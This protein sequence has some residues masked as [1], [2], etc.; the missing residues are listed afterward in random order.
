MGCK[1]SKLVIFL[2]CM[3]Q[4]GTFVECVD[5]SGAK[6]GKCLRNISYPHKRNMCVGNNIL[7]S[8]KKRT[9][10]GQSRVPNKMYPSVLVLPSKRNYRID[11]SYVVNFK[12]SC[13]VVYTATFKIKGTRL[14]GPVLKEVFLDVK[15]NLGLK[16]VYR[17][18]L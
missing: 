1:G 6:L 11:G 15:G 18:M 12:G 10:L 7:I 9:A 14:T 3:T 13:V 5:N 17:R 2:Y 16:K 4:F 8:I